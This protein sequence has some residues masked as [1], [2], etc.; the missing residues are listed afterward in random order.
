[1]TPPSQSACLGQLPGA[2]DGGGTVLPPAGHFSNAG[3]GAF[4]WALQAGLMG[5]PTGLR[6]AR[7]PRS[8][9]PRLGPGKESGWG[10]AEQ[11]AG[12]GS[13]L[14]SPAFCPT[15]FCP[16]PPV[17]GPPEWV[18]PPEGRK[19]PEGAEDGTYAEPPSPKGA[20]RGTH[21]VTRERGWG[22]L[23]WGRGAPWWSLGTKH[24]RFGREIHRLRLPARS[25]G[26]TPGCSHRLAPGHG[27]TL[28][29]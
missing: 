14:L 24:C 29:C 6:S 16:Q 22:A 4:P 19:W 7:G 8:R 15:A 28:G 5:L 20:T 25:R 2:Q 23:V 9:S 1:M 21:R 11:P 18:W 3:G 12:T 27:G 26:L 13:C 10:R 17:L